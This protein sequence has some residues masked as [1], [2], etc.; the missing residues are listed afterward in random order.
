MPSATEKLVL[1]ESTVTEFTFH[2]AKLAIVVTDA[3]ILS[4]G[5]YKL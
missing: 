2:N 4:V 5:K 3:G 1:P